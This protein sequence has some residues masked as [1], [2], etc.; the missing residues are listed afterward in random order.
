M[1]SKECFGERLFDNQ[2]VRF[3]SVNVDVGV[4]FGDCGKSEPRLEKLKHWKGDSPATCR[5]WRHHG[6][7]SFQHYKR[8]QSSR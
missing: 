8:R 5:Y 6:R 3:I 1:V 2:R 7:I 4:R